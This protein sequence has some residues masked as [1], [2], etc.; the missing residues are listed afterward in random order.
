MVAYTQDGHIKLS[1]LEVSPSKGEYRSCL[2][3]L[4]CLKAFAWTMTTLTILLS[5]GRYAISAASKKR[6]QWDDLTHLLA[7]LA[8]ITMVGLFQSLF[9]DGYYITAIEGR[10]I[11]M[12]SQEIFIQIYVRFRH[13]SDGIALLFFT[14]T[15]L[16]KLTFLILYRTIFQ[17]N[18]NFRKAWWAV[19]SFVFVTYWVTVAGVLTQCGP[20]KNSFSLGR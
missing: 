9:R 16:V 18:K 4:T 10:L 20:A 14:S 11:P 5:A 15:W 19:L 8:M 2:D 6:S 13:R 3:P 17:I 12:P 1:N 7:L